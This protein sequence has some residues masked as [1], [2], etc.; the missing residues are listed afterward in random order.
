MKQIVFTVALGLATLVPSHEISAQQFSVTPASPILQGEPVTISLTGLPAN[1]DIKIIAERI[2][3]EWG[4]EKRVL[5]RAEATFGVGADGTLDLS[6]VAP[7]Q[8]SY[9]QVDPR[10]L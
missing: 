4:S 2:M 6:R 1:Q 9:K 8:G 7:K 3:T 10:G 5:Y